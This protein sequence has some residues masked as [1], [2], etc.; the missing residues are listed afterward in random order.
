MPAVPFFAAG[1]NGNLG[2]Q[3]RGFGFLHDGSVDTLFRFHGAN[4]FVLLSTQDQADLEALM[5]VFDSNLAPIVGQQITLGPG[6]PTAVRQRIDLLLARAAAGEC[7]VIV[8]GTVGG[9]ARGWVRLAAG[10]FQSDRQSE[11]PVSEASLRA[12]AATVGQEHTYTCVPPGSGQRIGVDRDDDGHFDRTEIDAGS[13]PADP[14]SIPPGGTTTSTSST[15]STSLPQPPPAVMI[16]T[17][18]LRLKA[19]SPGVPV[20]KIKLESSTAD[21][22]DPGRIVPGED[23]GPGDPRL[24]GG[25][26][27]VYSPV[28]G[29]QVREPL[30][31]FGWRVLAKKGAPIGYEFA[32]PAGGTLFV[33]SVK[34]KADKVI[35]KGILPFDLGQSPQ[36]RL[37]FRLSVG[38]A[39]YCGEAPAKARGNPPSTKR[40]DNRRR[41]VASPRTPPPGACAVP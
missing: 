10:T 35:V 18:V 41:F 39:G 24:H 37:A 38:L 16:P 9:L 34:I 36:E 28:T 21:E 1:N 17:T 2:D 11:T 29:Q 15:T 3:V 30:R 19:Q 13:D 4:V 26:L 31:N 40:F 5:H 8:K 14:T 33:R 22:P 12:Q 27:V 6:S 7:D 25:E 20:V 23:G 32:G